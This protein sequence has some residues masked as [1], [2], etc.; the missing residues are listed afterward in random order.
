MPSLPAPRKLDARPLLR[1]AV[2]PGHVRVGP[3]VAVPSVLADPGVAPAPLLAEFDLDVAAFDDPERRVPCRT[4][5]QLFGR[6]VEAT[7]CQH[8]GLLVGSRAGLSSLGVAGYLAMRSVQ[9]IHDA[10]QLVL[11][12]AVTFGGH[13]YTLKRAQDRLISSTGRPNA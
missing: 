1:Q 5:A 8:F 4:V 13:S 11:L 3:I 9:A 2:A 12:D 6:C 10:S 7:S